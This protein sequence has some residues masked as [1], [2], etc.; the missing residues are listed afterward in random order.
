MSVAVALS[1]E[2]HVAKTL[3]LDYLD[4]WS[5]SRYITG[6]AQSHMQS[7]SF[8]Y[9]SPQHG[10]G[11]KAKAFT[12]WYD[13]PGMSETISNHGGIKSVVKEIVRD[14]GFRECEIDNEL[15]VIEALL[16]D[17]GRELLE[18]YAKDGPTLRKIIEDK[19]EVEEY[20]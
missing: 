7:I 9:G 5:S 18:S 6:A 11:V 14:L 15:E 10:M 3:K 13:D 20:N 19:L 17:D 8:Q 4:W 12:G 16:G 2:P 1:P